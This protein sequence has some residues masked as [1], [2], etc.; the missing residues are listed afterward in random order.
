MSLKNFIPFPIW[1][2]LRLTKLFF[3][4]YFFR[5]YIAK[6]TYLGYPL[7]VKIG[8]PLSKGWYDFDWVSQAQE[9][10]HLIR[11]VH[12]KN[13]LIYDLGSHQGIVAMILANLVGKRG[14]VIAVEANS[15]NIRIFRQNLRLNNLKNI[16]IIQA[17]VSDSPGKVV[18]NRGLNGQIDDGTGSWG[19]QICPGIT[20]AQMNKKYGK[21]DVIFMDIEGAEG[22]VIESIN[23]KD[24]PKTAWVIEVHINHGLEQLGGKVEKIISKFQKNQYKLY[25]LPE[26]KARLLAYSKSTPIPRRRFHLFALPY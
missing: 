9:I 10:K 8:D 21:P 5:K 17:A 4:T 15:H 12:L 22:R 3:N 2:V 25:Y 11:L 19:R 18:F 20:L 7:L 1:R 6:H 14:Q 24:Y 26:D 13:A 23:I 16:Q